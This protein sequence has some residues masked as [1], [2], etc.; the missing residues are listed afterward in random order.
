MRGARGLGL[1]VGLVAA[2]ALGTTA[3]SGGG[4]GSSSATTSSTTRRTAPRAPV[5]TTPSTRAATTTTV[6]GT[7]T[8]GSSTTTTGAG[9]GATPTLGVAGAFGAGAVGFGQV[10]PPEISLGGDPTG[11]LVGITW[12]SWGGSQA[13]GSGTSTYVGPGQTVAQGTDEAA[14]VVAYDLGTCGGSP[15]YQQVT[16]YFPEQGQTPAD[17]GSTPIDACTGP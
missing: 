1:V 9:S 10:R 2:L 5:S 14:T 16:W 11:I 6:A 13:T 4:P 3:C 12:Q 15:A 8:T 7:T 17:N